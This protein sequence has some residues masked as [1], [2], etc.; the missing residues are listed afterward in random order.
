MTKMGT[1]TIMCDG[2]IL[3]NYTMQ[4]I[5]VLMYWSKILSPSSG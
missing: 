1:I 5:F 4:Q 2:H 3:A